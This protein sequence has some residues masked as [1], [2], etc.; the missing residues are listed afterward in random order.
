[1]SAT[2]SAESGRA[3]STRSSS[4]NRQRSRASD[5]GVVTTRIGT[6]AECPNRA[7]SAG[8]TASA[9]RRGVRSADLCCPPVYGGTLRLVVAR[10]D[11]QPVPLVGL[12]E[13]GSVFDTP[14][15]GC[16]RYPKPTT[17]DVE[18]RIDLR[19]FVSDPRELLGVP[20]DD[21]FR[22]ACHFQQGEWCERRAVDVGHLH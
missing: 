10:L 15:L 14:G 21:P 9:E 2:S 13:T 19:V 18:R 5:R 6:H 11:D 7:R 20:G 1:M 8:P 22:V 3:I 16:T 17:S 12:E 4:P